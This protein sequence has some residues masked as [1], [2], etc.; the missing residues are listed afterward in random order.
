MESLN[1]NNSW[2]IWNQFFGS[3]SKILILTLFE[4]EYF[5]RKLLKLC[6]NGINDLFIGTLFQ[7]AP[8]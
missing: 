7:N 8:P 5:Y 6:K 4:G 2:A 1:A 3:K